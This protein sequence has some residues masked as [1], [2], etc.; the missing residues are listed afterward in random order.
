MF[1]CMKAILMKGSPL[2]EFFFVFG[3]LVKHVVTLRLNTKLLYKFFERQ[4][5]D[6]YVFQLIAKTNQK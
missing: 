6:I 5:E 3:F 2:N 1:E 4:R